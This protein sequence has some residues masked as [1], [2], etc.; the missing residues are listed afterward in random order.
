MRSVSFSRPSPILDFEGRPLTG[1]GQSAH[2]EDVVYNPRHGTVWVADERDF[3]DVARP[4]LVEL[5]P[6]SGRELGRLVPE[7]DGPLSVYAAI[8]A[9]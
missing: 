4:S 8:R 1:P 7:G 9:N 6:E 5:D 2:P 3:G